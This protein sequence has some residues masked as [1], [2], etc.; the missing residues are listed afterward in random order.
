MGNILGIAGS[1]NGAAA[2]YIE[3]LDKLVVLEIERLLNIKNA[4]WATY[5]PVID[6]NFCSELVIKYFKENYGITH[7]D[8]VRS[9]S[10]DH[11]N[12]HVAYDFNFDL[13]EHNTVRYDS[14]GE[15]VDWSGDTGDTSGDG[16]AAYHHKSHAA[17]TFYQSSFNNA[18]VFSFDGGGDDGWFI[19]Y[20]LDRS[21]P[22]DKQMKTIHHSFTDLG[23]P[24]FYLGYF[25][26]DI[27]FIRDYGEACLTF[28]GKLMGYCS[29][30]NV[31]EDWIE[32]LRVYYKSWHREGWTPVENKAMQ[33]CH[34]LG[35]AIGLQFCFDEDRV[36]LESTRLEGQDAFDLIATSQKVFED[37]FFEEVKH[38]IDE[39][40]TNVCLTGGCALNIL[41]NTKIRDYVQSYG[42]DVFVAPNSSDCGLA[43]G[44]VLDHLR[45][46][47]PVDVT[48][49]GE[50]IF[51]IDNYFYY[52]GQ[53]RNNEDVDLS[54]LADEIDNNLIFGLVQGN[55]EH[56]PRALGNRSIIC[57]PRI[58]MKAILNEKV[59]GREYY[60]PFAPVVR[61]E[62]V[63]EYFEWEGECRHMNFAA[64][65]K[66]QYRSQLASITHQDNTARIQT[67]TRE[68]NELLYDLL[69][70]MDNKNMIPVLLNTSF[71]LAGKPILNTYKDA[72]EVLSKTKMDKLL[73]VNKYTN[74]YG[75]IFSKT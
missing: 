54:K 58:G 15:R 44:L 8:L 33:F 67:I 39:Y 43:T 60:R 25:I 21:K 32:P 41:N 10:S 18:L 64:I 3:Q 9:I 70:E 72:F 29:Y 28:A 17:N 36:P 34:T 26:K 31:R 68:Q 65:V 19:G 57:S 61:L 5:N 47:N 40:K 14:S 75:R 45:P 46:Q 30:G 7:F 22:K 53:Y 66:H 56:G 55:S 27:S 73:I 35:N 38:L 59:K 1:H 62:D 13:F 51:D 37:L 42:K 50:P 24:Y 16:W 20:H 6:P 23:N 63:S 2:L 12:R 48:Y 49:A 69:T 52:I 74:K 4:A 11:N 71:N